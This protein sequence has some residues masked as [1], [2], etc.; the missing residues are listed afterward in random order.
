MP[1][2]HIAIHI[3]KV[4]RQS[5]MRIMMWWANLLNTISIMKAPSLSRSAFMTKI[6]RLCQHHERGMLNLE[7]ALLFIILI[8]DRS[9]KSKLISIKRIKTSKA[10]RK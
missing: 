2:S 9:C 5:P 1:T 7:C 8:H 4:P 6:A 3:M 10:C